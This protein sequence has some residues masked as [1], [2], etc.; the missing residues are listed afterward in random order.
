MTARI[1]KIRFKE[2]ILIPDEV[3]LD[4]QLMRQKIAA[5]IY[6]KARGRIRND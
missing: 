1:G 6:H 2:E 3:W 4:V 5:D